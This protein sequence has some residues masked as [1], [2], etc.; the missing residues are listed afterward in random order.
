MKKRIVTFAIAV[1][2]CFASVVF[3]FA[4]DGFDESYC[5]VVDNAE[6]IT[7]EEW[8][9]L[10]QKLN[11]I[12]VRQKVD[13]AIMT[14]KSADGKT[15]QEFADYVYENNSYGYGENFDGVMLVVGTQARS[16]HITTA[17]YGIKAFTDSAIEYIGQQMSPYLSSGDYFG[18]FNVYLEKCD[19]LITMSKNGTPYGA[20]SKSN[21]SLSI[22]WIPISIAIGVII[23]FI[24]VKKM[25]NDL[26]SVRKK[27]EANSYVKNASM[28]VNES[29]DSFLYS[30]VSKTPIQRQNTSSSS[31]HKSSSGNSR[32]GGGGH[33]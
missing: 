25:K 15:L 29:Y 8:K 28:V 21:E 31:T 19:E 16:W 26:K 12:R 32:G 20:K 33:F 27:R 22:V 4:Q 23:A 30:Q 11:E 5:R 6:L 18:A 17:G 10:T 14:T 1:F 13:I 24:V 7:N 9:T 2:L 3:V